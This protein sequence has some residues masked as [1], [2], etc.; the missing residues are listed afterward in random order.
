MPEYVWVIV[1]VIL[2]VVGILSFRVRFDV[3]EWFRDR[4]ERRRDQVKVL[5]PHAEPVL[6]EDGDRRIRSFF[7]SPS[8]T[9]NFQCGRC[10]LVV[11]D[12]DIIYRL[13]AYWEQHPKD[14]SAREKKFQS[15]LK[16]LGY[17]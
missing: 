12:E 9:L 13:M 17:L 8:G 1:V 6:D 16:K 4:Y 14:L 2:G 10:G 3:N 5:C 15:H 7:V 11:N